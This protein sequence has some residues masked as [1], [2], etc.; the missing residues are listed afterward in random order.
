MMADA[1]DQNGA[2]KVYVLGR[3]LDKLQEVAKEAVNYPSSPIIQFKM[4]HVWLKKNGSLVPIQADVTSTEDLQKAAA[5][6]K[7]EVGFVNTVI[8]NSGVTGP[9]N[10]G[11]PQ[12]RTPTIAEI[13]EHILKTPQE[14]FTQT[15]AVNNTA[16]F[17][18]MA[19]FLELL[20][21]GNKSD[22]S[23]AKA[24][25]IKSQFIATSSIGGLH[26]KAFAG[27]AYPGSKAGVNHL[28]KVLATFLV[29]HHIRCNVI[30]PGMYPSEMNHSVSFYFCIKTD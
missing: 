7:S 18:T 8:A 28:I 2:A 16:M 17:Y 14:D 24:Q 29:P 4:A 12:D 11:L 6:I 22:K 9:L 21:A 3:R 10:S 27:F 20:D 15:F 25:G 5:Q 30:A 1:L 19:A 23:V 26:R 13:Q